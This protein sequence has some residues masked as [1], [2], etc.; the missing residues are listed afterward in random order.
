MTDRLDTKK[1]CVIGAGN[2]GG[3]ILRQMLSSNAFAEVRGTRRNMDALAGIASQ[4][5]IIG[6]DN[7]TAILQSDIVLLCVKP[8]DAPAVL[9]EIGD[10][11]TG[12]LVISTM[13]GI[14]IG[15]LQKA[16][17][18]A[19]IM[20]TMPNMG[21]EVCSSS[22]ALC[23]SVGISQ[24]DRQVAECIFRE[25]G[26]FTWVSEDKMAVST[27]IMGTGPALV[28]LVMAAFAE[29]LERHGFTPQEAMQIT[30]EVVSGAAEV[31]H[32]HGS[33][34]HESRKLADF[35]VSKITSKNGTTHA[36]RE[37]LEGRD[38]AEILSE[39]LEAAC[40]RA[41]ELGKEAEIKMMLEL[42]KEVQ[43]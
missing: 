36:M 20:R 11:C 33:D 18:G 23:A 35:L 34:F 38:F 24:E 9:L 19:R 30:Y 27:A 28:F 25:I 43:K 13:A 37:K 17:P 12:K 4:G 39:A 42:G 41:M 15:L 1:L 14:S 5:A 31:W 2:I 8:Q 40:F 22:T 29:T 7:C 26:S 16:L 32:K 3:T 6:T 21:A 10:A